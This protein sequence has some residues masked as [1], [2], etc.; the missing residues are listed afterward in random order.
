MS[1]QITTPN[2]A[3]PVTLAA[4]KSRLRLTDTTDDALITSQIPVARLFAEKI[5]RRSL[6]LKTYAFSLD[7]FPDWQKPI[8][9]PMPPLV[10]VLGITFLDSTLTQQTWDP[11]DYY[12]ASNQ[13]PA[14]IVPNPGYIYPPIARVPG[15]VEVSFTAGYTVAVDD[16]GAPTTDQHFGIAFESICRLCVYLYQTP[17]AVLS[18]GMKEDP[19]GA[20]SMLRSIKVYEF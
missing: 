8:R 3:E 20:I 17:D 13:S 9:I 18:E 1:L 19:L 12:T 6:A 2:T 11:A 4:V 5:T 14:L 10:S 7:R 16:G 15:A